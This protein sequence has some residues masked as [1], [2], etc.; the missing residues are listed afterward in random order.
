M[1]H[2]GWGYL[3]IIY[4]EWGVAGAAIAYNLSFCLNFLAQE[5]YIRCCA[6]EF[7]KDFL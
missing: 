7:F 3:F 2:V 5:I 1:F 4:L 6:R